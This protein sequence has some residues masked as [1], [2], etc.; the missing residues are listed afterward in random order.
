M[1][2]RILISSGNWAV[3]SDDRQWMLCRTRKSGPREPLSFVHS[4]K[5]ILARCMREKGCPP[6]DAAVLL[7]A[8][9]DRFVEA[10]AAALETA[11]SVF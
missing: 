7:A 3:V 9:P 6:E 8:L 10:T 2:D 5:D 11:Y 1:T 4:T